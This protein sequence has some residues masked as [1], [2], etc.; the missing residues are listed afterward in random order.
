MANELTYQ[1]VFT[2]QEMDER[3]TAVAQLQAALLE[4]ETALSAKYVKPASGIPETDL[5]SA[6]QSA[7][8][9]A[10]SAVQDLSNYY[11]K[12]EIDSLLA[13][14]NS[15]EYVDVATL[16]T[17]SAST[18]GKIYLVGPTNN[19]YDRYYTSYDGSAYSWVAAGSTEINLSNYAT[20]AE[21]NQLDQKVDEKADQADLSQLEAKVDGTPRNYTPGYGLKSDGTLQESSYWGVTDYIPYTPGNDV[22]WRFSNQ[23]Q[24]Y[25]L[26]FYR[27]DKTLISG[28]DFTAQYNSTN[29]GRLIAKASINSYAPNAA[30]IRASFNLDYAD[31]QIKV[32]DTVVWT[33]QEQ[34]ISLQEQIDTLAEFNEDIFADCLVEQI[35]LV[36][37]AYQGKYIYKGDH[38][39][40]DSASNGSFVVPVTTGDR[41]LVRGTV[42]AFANY[43]VI[44]FTDN[45]TN[46]YTA[47]VKNLLTVDSNTNP[48]TYTYLFTATANGYLIAWTTKQGYGDSLYVEMFRIKERQKEV[49]DRYLPETVKL[50]TFGDSI[51]DNFWGDKSSWVSYVPDN[52]KNTTLTIVNSAVGG[53]SIGG[54]GSYNIP[55]QIENG[56]TRTDGSVA[57][58]LDSTA[59]VVVIFAG[60]NDWAAGQSLES[61]KGNLATSFQY[62][63]EHSKAK[64]L[65][66]T[67]LQRYND[68]DQ[69]RDT[70]ENGVPI[71][72]LGMT[73]R[74]LCDE[75]IEVCKRFSVPVLDLNAEANINRYNI[76]DYSLDGLHPQRWGDAYVSRLIC[77]KI[78]AMLRYDLQ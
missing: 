74:E 7:L 43:S 69:A 60:T 71:N 78:K 44:G 23:N 3:F 47:G 38:S 15:Q 11:T 32:G 45:L 70:D 75:L 22:L 52:I 21:L 25:F 63:Y 12:T 13:A 65:F 58:P 54:T 67:P 51:T 72:P 59:D 33:P 5:D 34:G 53:A 31:A 35:K 68:A 46:G 64:V 24:S 56:Y 17:A 61:V 66:C 16:P 48:Y 73:L 39:I 20:K 27:S 55:N 2:G 37:V 8:A 9:K 77:E 49:F 57:S 26:L 36:G 19:Q 4:V 41:I 29:Q 18:L 30:Y 10:R 40:N 62:I 14:V 42:N 76:S 28:S 6:V 1:S 50:Q